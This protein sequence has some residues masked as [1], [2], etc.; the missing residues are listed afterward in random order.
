MISRYSTHQMDVVWCTPTRLRLWAEVEAAVARAQAVE[1]TIPFAAAQRIS[2]AAVVMGEAWIVE[3]VEAREAEIG[4]DFAAF[5]DVLAK[6]A[7]EHQWVHYGLTSSDVEDVV[8]SVQCLNSIDV[9]RSDLRDLITLVVDEMQ[10]WGDVPQVGRTHGQHAE[11]RL[12]S[13]QI[14]LWYC[15]LDRAAQRLTNAQVAL[16]VGSISGPVGNH[17]TVSQFVEAHALEDFGLLPVPAGQCLDRDVYADYV[18]A[19]A[20][21]GTVIERIATQVRLLAQTEVGE[22]TEG[23]LAWAKGSSSMPH[24]RNPVRSERLC[25]LARLL[26]SYVSPALENVALWHDRDISHSSV[27][28]VIL[29]DASHLAHYALQELHDLIVEWNVDTARMRAHAELAPTSH[30]R[31]LD[32]VGRGYDRDTAYRAVQEDL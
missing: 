4:H 31:M 2:S 26:R 1:E 16:S 7:Q 19:L 5:V 25:G 8:L 14:R 9:L 18:Y 10:R 24:K 15:A 23:T 6:V 28:R 29:P 27:E 30:A 21:L 22:V 17:R 3:E 13:D 20:S 32:L 12:F 11:A